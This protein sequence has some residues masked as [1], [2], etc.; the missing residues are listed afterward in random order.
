VAVLLDNYQ[1]GNEFSNLR[2]IVDKARKVVS[3]HTVLNV[4]ADG[5]LAAR[6]GS[7]L[8]RSRASA[9]DCDTDRDKYD[10]TLDANRRRVQSCLRVR[11]SSTYYHEW[12]PDR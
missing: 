2:L 6:L 11:C 5:R 7:R 12:R 9:W 3:F 1:T 4:E 10:M 8:W